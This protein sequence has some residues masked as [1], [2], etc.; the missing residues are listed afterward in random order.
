MDKLDALRQHLIDLLTKAEAHVD[1]RSAI[2]DFPTHLAGR[3]AEGAPHTPWQLLEHIRI[4]Q[5]DILR[6]ILEPNHVSPEFPKGYWPANDAPAKGAWQQSVKQILSDLD[7]MCQLVRDPKHDLFTRIPHG[8]GQTLLREAL[9]V[10]DHNAYHL[11][12]IVL[13]RRLLVAGA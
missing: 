13:L 2:E 8:T 9:L 7:E 6:F 11:G 4:A 1:L 5:Q 3:K 12:Q 10:A